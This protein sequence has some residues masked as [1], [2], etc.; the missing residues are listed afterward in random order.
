[1]IAWEEAKIQEPKRCK[2]KLFRHLRYR[3]TPYAIWQIQ[4]QGERVIKVIE[5][6]DNKPLFP[7]TK[8]FQITMRLPSAHHPKMLIKDNNAIELK[9]IQWHC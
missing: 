5:I 8:S 7:F 9:Y 2:G 6:G 4:G 3:V 1:M